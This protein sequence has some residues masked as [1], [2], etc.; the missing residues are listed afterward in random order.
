MCGIAG[1]I[2]PKPPPPERLQAASTVLRHR[3]PDGEGFY[4]HHLQN[5]A[6]AL[7]HRRLAIIDLDPRS[8]QPFRYQGTTLA[9]NGEIYNYLEIRSE[10]QA[11]GHHFETSSDTEV[12]SHALRQWGQDAL[13]RL[14]GMWAFAWYDEQAGT[15]LL[16]RDRFGEK[17]LYV[18]QHA[19]AL[20]F[21]SEPKA[22]FALLG[23]TLPVN[24]RHLRRYL[25]NGYKSL[26]KTQDTF[27]SGLREI[28]S[29]TCLTFS[30]G[31]STAATYW[32]PHVDQ[33]DPSLSYDQAVAQA[34]DALI[35]SVELRLRADVPIAFCLSGG[36]D[37]NALIAIAKRHL[38]YDVHGFT[39]AN[40]DARYEERDMVDAAVRAH[41][42]RHTEIPI[43]T[44]GFLDHLRAQ[45]RAHD[46]P[47]YTITYYAQW[48][49]MEAI[50]AAGYKVSVSGTA[51]DELF[52]GYYDHHNAYLAAMKGEDET[53]YQQALGEWQDVVAP[54]VRNPFLGDPNYLIR[55]PDAR[56]HIYL[57]APLF[58]EMLHEPFTEAF[59]E[60][61]YSTTLL[62]NRMANELR[63]ET[64]PVILHED[65]LNA[66]YCSIENRSPFLDRSVFDLCQR[67]PTRH[68]ISAGRAKAVLRD[69][70]RGLAP[71]AIIDNPR[72]V[73]FNVPLHDYLDTTAPKVQ[74]ALLADS[75]IYTLVKREAIEPLLHQDV[76]PNSR[77]KFL[78]NF[79]CAKLFL[80]EFAS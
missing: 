24:H 52:S 22:I 59:A 29:G 72:K 43:S 48:R 46:A 64:V 26:Y 75:P 55:Q 79:I 21:G 9:F 66:M 69:A 31:R 16:S 3:G 37:S 73:G 25:V 41:D 19:D 44:D 10:L 71:D 78:F 51:A 63:H 20:Y 49:L 45:V 61:A 34:R 67:L 77:S 62:R 18:Y 35:R 7:V 54:I 15:L 2:G 17:P 33:Q 8:D 42:L 53:R 65:D 60:T 12:L 76:L 74:E 56:D 6:V 68:L 32:Q 11:I 70:L 1:Y 50:H 80:E 4:T 28:P 58:A 40:T 38:G 47:I 30:Q 36:V 27:F 39:I 13:D 5:Q 57:D 23:Q 14:E